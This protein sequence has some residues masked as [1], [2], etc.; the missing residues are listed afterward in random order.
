MRRRSS[1][2]HAA[3]AIEDLFA[4][5]IGPA[6]RERV[7][8]HLRKTRSVAQT[9]IEPLPGDRVQTLRGIADDRQ[10]RRGVPIGAGQ[11]QLVTLTTTDAQQPAEPQPERTL[12]LGEKG[13][14]RQRDQ[15][16]GFVRRVGPDE[17]TTSVRERQHGEWPVRRKPLIGHVVVE[18]LRRDRRHDGGLPV[19]PVL[20][21]DARA[22]A[23]HRA[24]TVCRDHEPRIEPHRPGRGL[25][26]EA[27]G[28]RLR[29]WC[30]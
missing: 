1:A 21:R 6:R 26:F 17:T 24:R 27:A 10:A 14:V 3:Y 20:G 8:Q 9:E 4:A 12:Q 7:G 11:C 2:R 30:P 16:R 19:V 5:W 18:T 13:V 22:F 23:Q 25:D 29:S 15:P 28:S